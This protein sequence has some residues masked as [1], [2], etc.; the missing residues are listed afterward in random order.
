[1][2]PTTRKKGPQVGSAAQVRHQ[3]DRKLR[4]LRLLAQAAANVVLGD[5]VTEGLMRR[6]A[7]LVGRALAAPHLAEFDLLRLVSVA[8]GAVDARDEPAP[9][10]IEVFDEASDLFQWVTV[11]DEGA[12]AWLLGGHEARALRPAASLAA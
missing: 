1:M 8:D 4:A 6:V 12:R 10:V 5:A 7:E 9:L 11:E 3:A 2:G